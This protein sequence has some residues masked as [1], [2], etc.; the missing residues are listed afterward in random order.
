VSISIN[1]IVT[2]RHTVETRTAFSYAPGGPMSIFITSCLF[3]THEDTVNNACGLE[4]SPEK[5]TV[6]CRATKSVA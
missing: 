2:I 3:S 5:R 6:V 1:S 4:G